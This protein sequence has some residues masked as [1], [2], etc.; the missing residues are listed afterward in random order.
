MNGNEEFNTMLKEGG[1][2]L[3]QGNTAAFSGQS[4]KYKEIY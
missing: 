1:L 4:D 2:G 3:S